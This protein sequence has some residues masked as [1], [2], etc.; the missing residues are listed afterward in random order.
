MSRTAVVR[1]GWRAGWRGA[2]RLCLSCGTSDGPSCSRAAVLSLPT[3]S[4]TRNR[5]YAFLVC[6][7]MPNLIRAN[8]HPMLVQRMQDPSWRLI[9]RGWLYCRLLGE[10]PSSSSPT[11]STRPSTLPCPPR[12]CAAFPY[13]APSLSPTIDFAPIGVSRLAGG[14]H[15]GD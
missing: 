6:H 11:P 13:R 4:S 15:G 1:M 5:S 2:T 10:S 12:R 8:F 9:S 7:V 14:H 3:C